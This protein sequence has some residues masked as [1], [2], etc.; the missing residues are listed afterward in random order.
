MTPGRLTAPALALTTALCM[1][2]LAADAAAPFLAR[3]ATLDHALLPEASGL[4]VS[5]R[6]DRHLWLI[7]DSGNAPELF[8]LDLSDGRQRRLAV[9]DAPNRDWEDLAA[10]RHDDQ[11]WLA[12]ADVGD[13]RA[14]RATVQLYLLPEPDPDSDIAQVHTAITLR[15]AD[16]PRDAESV[17]IDSPSRTLYVLS[18][19]DDPPVL[20]SA[21]LPA[22]DRPGAHTLVLERRGPVTSIPK[23]TEEELR[24]FR[25]YG[26]YRAQPTGMS[27]SPAGDVVAL[28]TYRGVYRAQ[29]GPDRDWLQA[30]NGSL[31][32]VKG[33]D[34]D[35]AES[36]AIDAAGR[37]YVT[38]EGR[39]APLLRLDARC[40]VGE[41]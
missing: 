39:D 35:Q 21:A 9:L 13:N 20:Y 36:V 30:L 18:K 33:L 22:L 19:R 8:A 17:A 25:K 24:S 29:L 14:E 10:F 28:L 23:P 27:V 15:Y 37:I 34:L 11:P 26:R 2:A 5:G 6:S 4:A 32:L 7:N 3:L 40:P 1:P 16:G 31:C 38:S 12:I 41:P